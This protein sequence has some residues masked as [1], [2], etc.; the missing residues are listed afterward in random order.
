MCRLYGGQ[1][2]VLREGLG[3]QTPERLLGCAVMTMVRNYYF[4]M[5]EGMAERALPAGLW[6]FACQVPNVAALQAFLTDS[7]PI[8][9]FIATGPPH[10]Y[11]NDEEAVDLPPDEFLLSFS[12]GR[13]NAIAHRLIVRVPS[14]TEK[15]AQGHDLLLVL[16]HDVDSKEHI[17]A[18]GGR[19]NFF[20]S[21]RDALLAMK[22]LCN[23]CEGTAPN[24]CGGC[25]QVFYCCTEHQRKDWA[26]HK[27]TCIALKAMSEKRSA[28]G[29]L[30]EAGLTRS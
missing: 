1:K 12:I 22:G 21:G 17:A 13:D 28:E 10:L 18:G 20:L 8:S 30:K 3:N 27:P 15:L 23:L 14:T 9:L 5:R 16:F 4:T 19:H 25:R 2:E 11:A 6:T 7:A 24:R 29:A 26:T